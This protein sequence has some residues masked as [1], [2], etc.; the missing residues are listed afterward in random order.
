MALN[1]KTIG[2]DK[3]MDEFE[4]NNYQDY[5][6]QFT[7]QNNEMLNSTNMHGSPQNSNGVAIASLVLGI[8]SMVTCCCCLLGLLLGVIG[9]VLACVDKKGREWDGI[10]IAGLVCSILGTILS[11]GIAIRFLVPFLI[12]GSLPSILGVS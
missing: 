11:L 8:C 6:S 1:C 2:A 7:V 10:L 4:Q 9:I 12:I 5:T 3:N